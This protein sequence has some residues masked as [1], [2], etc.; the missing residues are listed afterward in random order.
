MVSCNFS[1]SLSMLLNVADSRL[2]PG[3]L[4][5]TEQRSTNWYK[6]P[7]QN[8][9]HELWMLTVIDDDQLTG[10]A[11]GGVLEISFEFSYHFRHYSL[12]LV[13]H[14]QVIVIFFYLKL[15]RSSFASI[16]VQKKQSWSL[17]GEEAFN[18]VNLANVGLCFVP[19]ENHK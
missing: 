12:C 11:S 10:M 13:A 17:M 4:W 2:D 6:F 15:N 1:I 8:C 14:C 9:C 3:T 19:I 18:L 16:W 5:S 7:Y